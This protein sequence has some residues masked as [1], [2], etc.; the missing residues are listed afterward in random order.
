MVCG[1]LNPPLA[2][3]KSLACEDCE[4]KIYCDICDI[5]GEPIDG[6]VYEVDGIKYCEYC[7]DNKTYTCP[8]CNDRHFIDN[9]NGINIVPRLTEEENAKLKEKYIK[10]YPW[11]C[12]KV[13][14]CDDMMYYPGMGESDVYVCNNEDCFEQWIKD[15]LIEGHRPHQRCIDY[16]ISWYVYF[17]EL[18]PEARKEY[19]LDEFNS[20]EEYK[21]LFQFRMAYPSQFVD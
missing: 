20:N 3:E 12:S 21:D 7:Y 14:Y 10:S 18:K 11:S 13:K 5:C 4:A 6:E 17:D 15:N 1:Q 19:E 16:N 8:N 9:M 2:D